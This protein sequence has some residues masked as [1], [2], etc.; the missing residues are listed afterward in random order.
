MTVAGATNINITGNVKIF[1]FGIISTPGCWGIICLFFALNVQPSSWVLLPENSFLLNPGPIIWQEPNAQ[2]VCSLPQL[3]T[4]GA[5]MRSF[6]SLLAIIC[7]I[8]LLA[9]A[10]EPPAGD[11]ALGTQSYAKYEK[12]KVCQ[13]CHTDIYQQWTQAMMSQAY[14]HHWDEIEYFDLAVPHAELDPKVAGVKAGCNGCHAPIAFLA[15]DVP[16]PRPAENSRANESVSCDLCHTI[17]G[18]AGD[19]PFNFNWFTNPG[20]TKYGNKPGLESPH[21]DTELSEFIT[22]P[23]FCGT[24]HNEMSPYGVYVKATHLE[25]QEGPYAQEGVRC[26][27][28]HMPKARGKNL[29]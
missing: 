18:H 5:P 19:I 12:P 9:S 2:S 27:T 11:A 1:S 8:P 16:P 17:T 28:C 23:E 26:H 20:R 22:Q 10:Q 3:P 13:S 14:T 21:H 7:F 29:Y 25:W 15:G 6:L 4:K 24:C